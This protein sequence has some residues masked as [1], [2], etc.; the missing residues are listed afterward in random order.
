MNSMYRQIARL[1]GFLICLSLA[2]SAGWAQSTGQDSCSKPPCTSTAGTE[3]A[4]TGPGLQAA[5]QDPEAAQAGVSQTGY[6]NT[7][8]TPSLNGGPP[9]VVQQP[10][11]LRLLYA[12]S[13]TQGYDSEVAGP[14]QNIGSYTSTYEGYVAAAW[15]F[16]RSYVILQQDSSYTHFGSSLVQGHGF[17]ETALLAS[18]D[19]D[20]NLNWIFE[21]NSSIGNNTLTELLPLPQVIVNGIAVTSP[22]AVVSG[23]NLGFVWGTDV[24][25]TLNWKPDVRD[26]FS[27]RAE[28]ANHQFYGLDLHDNLSTFTLSYMRALTQRTYLGAYGLTR[29][30]TGTIFCDSYGFGVTGRTSPTERLFLQASGGPEFDST[31]CT[32]H[33]GFELHFAATYKINPKSYIYAVAD[34]ELSIGFLPNSTWQDDV[35]VGFAKQ[36]TRRLSWLVGGGYQRGFVIP[37]LTPYHGFYEQTELRQRLSKSFTVEATYRRFD[38]SI[39]GLN[40]HRNI[41]LFTLRWSPPK[42]DVQTAMYPNSPLSTGYDQRSGHEE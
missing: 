7:S 36:L 24:A 13:S 23:A 19:F 21:A 6:L 22:N 4:S 17:H 25:S 39:P 32:R 1:I 31:G 27:F 30:E 18:V 34:R 40:V 14:F 38:Q 29:H 10:K 11:H 12:L 37:S 9:I 20:P 5:N 16:T 42:H 41:V 3:P 28:N 15:R 2:A 26:I 8:Y 33:Q 35:G